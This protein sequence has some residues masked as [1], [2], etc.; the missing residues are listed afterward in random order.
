MLRIGDF[1]VLS[2]V[3]IRTLRHYD[4]LGLLEPAHV[5]FGTLLEEGI[6]TEHLRGML[7]LRRAEQQTHV[8]DE[9]QR[10]ARIDARLNLIETEGRMTTDV[11]I[12]ETAPQWIASI[13]E[14]T[15]SSPDVGRRYPEIFAALGSQSTG[16]LAVALWH[17]N[18][19]KER[20]VDAEAGVYVEGPVNAG[21]RVRVYK[22]AAATMAC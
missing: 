21:G 2:Q 14:I 18:E 22:L 6:T 15:P 19:S 9:Q 20:D 16:G 10:L 11:V 5:D 1:S 8:R 12:R 4:E 13:R 17:D 7:R 3:S